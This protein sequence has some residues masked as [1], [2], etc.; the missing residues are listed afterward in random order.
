MSFTSQR[1]AQISQELLDELTAGGAR[2]LTGLRLSQLEGEVYQVVDRVAQRVMRGVLEDQASQAQTGD[3]CPTCQSLLEDCEPDKKL[4]QTQRCQVQ[5]EQ[6]VKRCHQCRRDFFPS[7]G[8][9]GMS[10]G[11]N[12]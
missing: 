1:I 2:D 11:S 9:A 12:L 4:L 8:D 3:R 10:G 7:G 6:P 5:W